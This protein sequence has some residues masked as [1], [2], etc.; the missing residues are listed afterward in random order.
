MAKSQSD[1]DKEMKMKNNSSGW[2]HKRLNQSP[3]DTVVPKCGT[4]KW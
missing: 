2:R 3:N 4:S 1:N